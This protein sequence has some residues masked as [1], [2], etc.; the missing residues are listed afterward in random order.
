MTTQPARSAAPRRYAW[1]AGIGLIGLAALAFAYWF[2]YEPAPGIRVTWAPGVTPERQS[3]LERKYL[4]A[5]PRSPHPEQPRS[6]AYDL[7]DTSRNNI[8]A[9]VKDPAVIDTNDIDDEYFKVRLATDYGN[10]WMWMAYR[11]PVI[12]DDGIR[13]TLVAVLT[14]LSLVGLGGLVAGAETRRE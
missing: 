9:L 8:E 7:L 12:R 3:T 5:H 4:L 14:A 6:I 13:W 11:I 10:A 1:C 2:T